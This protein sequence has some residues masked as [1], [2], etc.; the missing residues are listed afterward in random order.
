MGANVAARAARGKPRGTAEAAL[1]RRCDMIEVVGLALPFFGLILLGFVAGRIWKSDE[2]GLA[3]LNIFAIYFAL[4]AMFFRLISETPF[5]QLAN[6]RFV[7]ATTSSTLLIL[8]LGFAFAWLVSRG[9]LAQSTVTALVGGYGNV[10]YMGPPLALVALGQEAVAPAALVFCFDVMLVFTLTPLLMAV[11]RPMGASGSRLVAGILRSVLLHPFILATICG[12]VAASADFT[13]PAPID[14]LLALLSGSAAP[15][16]L[17]ALGVTVACRPL[18]RLPV[19]LP[20]LILIKLVVHP[21]VAF[22]I[23]CWLGGFERIW[24]ETAVLMASLPPAATIYM[25]A[26]QYQ[27]YVQRA[28]SAILLGTAASVFTVTGMLYVVTHDLLP[29]EWFGG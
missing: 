29:W 4:P 10:G 6:G 13:P 26:V 16:A 23:L 9:D 18:K 3:W 15:T 24:V 20:G 11:A 21:V 14:R 7:A 19:E 1:A 8:V 25:I 17:F 12:A 22:A 5:E 2:S 27:T 28:S